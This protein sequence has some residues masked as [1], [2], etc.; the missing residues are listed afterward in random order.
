MTMLL[1]D[2]IAAIATR[3]GAG[4]IGVIRLSGPKAFDIP[5]QLFEAPQAESISPRC[6]QLGYWLKEANGERLDQVLV[7][8]FVAPHSYTGENVVEIQAHG[9]R[10]NLEQSSIPFLRLGVRPAGPANS[11]CVLFCMDAWI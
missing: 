5:K 11:P 4:G 1:D 9:G 7:V 6:M 10:L 2:T 8:H 3:H